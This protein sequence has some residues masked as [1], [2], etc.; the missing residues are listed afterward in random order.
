MKTELNMP[1]K[2][3][4]DWRKSEFGRIDWKKL[5]DFIK[6]E[7]ATVQ[8]TRTKWDFSRVFVF[9]AF[10]TCLGKCNAFA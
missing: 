1:R 4:R 10:I 3:I 9:L 8:K 7:R 2:K 6:Q 5:A